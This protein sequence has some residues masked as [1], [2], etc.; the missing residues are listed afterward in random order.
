[1]EEFRFVVRRELGRRKIGNDFLHFF[2]PI[3]GARVRGQQAP[4]FPAG[5]FHFRLEA[6]EELCR[7]MWVVAGAN[8][9]L[10]RQAVSPLLI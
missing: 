2:L 6:L 8:Q 9:I 10:S 1:V 4:G 5:M 7:R 3:D